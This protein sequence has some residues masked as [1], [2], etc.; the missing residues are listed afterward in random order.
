MNYVRLFLAALAATLVD[1]LYGF[2]VWG[3]LL[4]GEFARYPEIFRN[5]DMSGFPLMFTGI[6][7]AL[8][9]ASW[10]YAKGYERGSG[11]LE[12][13]RFGVV[14]GLLVGAYL[15]GANFGTMR[16]GKKLA[17]TYLLGGFGEW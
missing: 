12:G 3:K 15:A 11:L 10:A 7:V 4:N 9:A 8:C 5:G 13:V 1:G 2:V 6:F 17:L 16:I 14:A